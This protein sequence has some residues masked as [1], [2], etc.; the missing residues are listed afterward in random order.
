[1]V[2]EFFGRGGILHYAYQFCRALAEQDAEVELV[3]DQDYELEELPHN[4]AVRRIF[5]L[6]DP[7][8]RGSVEWSTSLNA[9][10]GR[11]WRRSLR[12]GVHYREWWRLIR[13]V[14]RER[15]DIVQFGEIRFAGDLVP[16]LMLRAGG[17]RLAD[18]CH[19][20]APFDTS[21]DSSKITKES[22]FHRAV[23][24]LIYSCFDA[25]FVHSEVNRRE[26]ARLYGGGTDRIHVIPHGNEKMFV[27]P[28]RTAGKEAT[29]YRELG[30][31]AGSPTALFFGTLTKYKGVEYLIDAFAE[32][33]RRIPKA[34]LII[35][36][37]PNPEIDVEEL[38]RRTAQLGI[39]DAVKF[40]LQYVPVED[41]A[42]IFA[43][44]DVV[45][46]PYLMIYQ[47]GALQVAYSF[48]K[49]AV[50][51]DVGGLSEAVIDGETGLLVPARDSGAL[52]E[53]ITALL[54]DPDRARRMGER[55]RELSETVYSWDGVARQV[56][57]VY[58]DLVAPPAYDVPVTAV[59]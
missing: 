45:V 22:R 57:R 25:I 48:G 55:A 4:F 43:A 7:R 40:Y 31:E 59:A 47:S 35:A 11:L 18:V 38:R 15:P 29:L 20:I 5:R 9:R 58:A 44:A 24:R 17:V 10:L 34:Q 36:G 21:G 37:F 13:L 8:P 56:H 30:L 41:V 32:V 23:F 39:S 1:M 26:F 19:N 16:L 46:F 50:A 51:T 2:V 14:R 42:G 52:A 3:T 49:P 27:N 28:D 33:R 53:A 12:A 6:W 54:A